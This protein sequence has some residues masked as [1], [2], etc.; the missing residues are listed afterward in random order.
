MKSSS[1]KHNT[2]TLRLNFGGGDVPSLHPHHL[3][4]DVWGR[5]LS[6]LLFEGLTRINQK[7]DPELTG[8]NS[9]A[10]SSDGTHYTFLLREQKWSDGS[11]VTASHYEH[12]WK[13]ALSPTSDS[14]WS[15]LLYVIK[16]AKEA[17]LNQCPLEEVNV[18]ALD[19]KTLE[20]QL[21]Y[22]AP[23]FLELLSH[24]IF[25][26]VKDLKDPICF[27]GPFVIDSWE[28][29]YCLH[30]KANSNFWNREAITLEAIDISMLKDP[31]TAFTLYEKGD[32]DWIGAPISTLTHEDSEYLMKKQKL[33]LHEVNR[34]FWI[35]FNTE[36]SPF[37]SAS[38]R[39]A[40]SLAFDRSLVESI[41]IGGKPLHTPLPK[42]LSLSR[43]S[44]DFNEHLA[45][46]S[47]Q[48]GLEE[49]QLNKASFPPIILSHFNAASHKRLM[50][51]LKESWENTLG[52]KVQLVGLDWHSFLDSLKKGNFQIGGCI[53]SSLVNDPIELL[54]RF[55]GNAIYNFSNWDCPSYTEKIMQARESLKS[56]SRRQFLREAE[57]ILAEEVP[58]L[59]ITDNPHAYSARKN[60]KGFIFDNAGS[61]DMAYSYF[62]D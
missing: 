60:L 10:I 3:Q 49:L 40:F 20:V 48:K 41:F 42:S 4:S 26:P 45:K 28:K 36:K 50:E 12:A 13:A 31:S 55:E 18:R 59:S 58:F 15:H 34:P 8:A 19:E 30:L 37:T 23:Y 39:Q 56:D 62:E 11:N 5:A 24:P 43:I 21:E 47:F 9:V 33:H 6:K 27:N 51:L 53:V 7:G 22:P 25:M 32:I 35:F 61:I 57:E 16:G 17:K 44:F 2:K 14:A 46:Q 29:E 38:I 52:I 1:H 54:E